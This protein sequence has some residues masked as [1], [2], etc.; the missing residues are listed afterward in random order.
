MTNEQWLANQASTERHLNLNNLFTGRLS[1]ETEW[2]PEKAERPVIIISD[3]K[4]Q[5]PVI[6]KPVTDHRYWND[7]WN[8]PA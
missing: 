4:G 8:Y 3:D 2:K 5:L 7:E 6:I 1:Q